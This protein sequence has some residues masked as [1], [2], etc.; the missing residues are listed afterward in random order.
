M[1]SADTSGVRRCHFFAVPA[2]TGCQ[3]S[4]SGVAASGEQVVGQPGLGAVD[5]RGDLVGLEDQRGA[6]GVGGLAQRDPAA[7]QFLGLQAVAAVGAAPGLGPAV[8]SEVGCGHAVTDVHDQ[9]SLRMVV[10]M[11]VVASAGAAWAQIRSRALPYSPA[12]SG[13]SM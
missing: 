12:S 8:A 4:A 1:T 9:I 2:M 3:G 7:G 5:E 10:R 6:P 11:P 13:L